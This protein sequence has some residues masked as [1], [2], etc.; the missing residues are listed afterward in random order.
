MTCAPNS[1]TIAAISTPFGEGAIA[2]LRLGGEHAIAIADDVFRG[3]KKPS[4][5]QPRVAE[6]GWIV[7]HDT[8]IDDALVTSK[9]FS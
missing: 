7:D 2:V 8:K 5:F 1:N 3:K 9:V 4:E 6:F